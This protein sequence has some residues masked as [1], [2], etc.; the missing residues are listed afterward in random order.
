MSD[1]A[2][3][4]TSVRDFFSFEGQVP[5]I[6]SVAY[7]LAVTGT[8]AVAFSS[9]PP[10]FMDAYLAGIALTHRRWTIGPALLMYVLSLICASY[11]LPPRGSV[12]VSEGYNLY[13]IVSY[14]IT[15]LI[16]MTAIESLKS[17]RD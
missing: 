5:Y 7:V 10:R 12:V 11:I 4:G 3:I 9:P 8:V 15:T 14:S 17:R 16:V 13:R 1:K 6:V 2:D